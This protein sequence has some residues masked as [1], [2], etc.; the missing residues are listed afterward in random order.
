M[1]WELVPDFGTAD[2]ATARGYGVAHGVR[3]TD[4]TYTS[5]LTGNV[6]CRK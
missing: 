4:G 3:N 6:E 1:R 2:L 5:T